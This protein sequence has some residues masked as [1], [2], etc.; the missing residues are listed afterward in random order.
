MPMPWRIAAARIASPA[1]TP[2]ARALGCTVTWNEPVP[3]AALVIF[4]YPQA[5]RCRR[6]ILPSIQSPLGALPSRFR[7][8]RVLI[9][10][11][12][13]VGQRIAHALRGRVVLRA[14]TSTSS[15][16]RIDSLR[17]AGV[18]PLRG[19]LDAPATLSRL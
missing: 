13:D 3:P 2:N 7:R 14:L 10:G 19:N 4:G 8:E 11:C 16:D 17:Q 15:P 1:L 9:V 18:T 5:L 12:G 6:P